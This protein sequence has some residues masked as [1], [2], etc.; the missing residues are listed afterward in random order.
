MRLLLDRGAAV[1][2]HYG[3]G[4]MTHDASYRGHVDALRLLLQHG[5]YTG[6]LQVVT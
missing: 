5:A 1:D 2:R 4:F 3:I 6:Q